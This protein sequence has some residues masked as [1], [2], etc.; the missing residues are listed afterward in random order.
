MITMLVCLAIVIVAAV[1]IW[2]LLE[3]KVLGK[4]LSE[5]TK[6]LPNEVFPLKTLLKQL[7]LLEKLLG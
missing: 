6:V 2:F 7:Y 5:S 3:D 1:A 4:R